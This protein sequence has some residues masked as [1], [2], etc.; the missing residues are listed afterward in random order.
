MDLIE[1]LG[2]M[3]ADIEVLPRFRK[4]IAQKQAKGECLKCA[5]KA[6]KRGLC[7]SH[8]YRFRMDKKDVTKSRRAA[9]EANAIRTGDILADRQGQ[10]PAP[11]DVVMGQVSE[12]A[13]V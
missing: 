11:V 12:G 4:F 8:Y 13:T 10:R 5:A 2:F 1:W 9:F 6:K 7:D 3:A